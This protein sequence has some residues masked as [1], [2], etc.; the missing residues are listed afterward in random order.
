[1]E[2]DCGLAQ[3]RS[4]RTDDEESLAIHANDR[5][6]WRNL[7][8]L[9]PHPYTKADAVQWIQLASSQKPQTNFAICVDGAAIGGIGV[10]L[11][12][13]IERCSGEVG[14]WI[15]KS[16]WGRGIATAVLQAFTRFAMKEYG[17]TRIYAHAFA[18]N[19]ASIRVLQKAGYRCEGRLR[20]SM[21]KD[22]RVQDQLMYAITDEDLAATP[23]L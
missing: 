20:R 8:D 12:T 23:Q 15:G 19:A 9:F 6:I 13:D 16:Y 10:K 14:Y 1:M 17:L 22:G 18:E 3:L 11:H 21:I 7:P 5:D 2:L 4:W